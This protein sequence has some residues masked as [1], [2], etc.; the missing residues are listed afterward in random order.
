MNDKALLYIMLFELSQLAEALH[1]DVAYIE[2][3]I[4]ARKLRALKMNNRLM[5]RGID[6]DKFLETEAEQYAL[7]LQKQFS[8]EAIKKLAIKRPKE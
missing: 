5:V 7:K 4:D 1:V 3:L 2:A 8:D 6:L